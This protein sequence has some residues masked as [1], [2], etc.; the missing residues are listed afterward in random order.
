MP[1]TS[2][3]TGFLQHHAREHRVSS[4]EESDEAFS[5]DTH[6]VVLK[7]FYMKNISPFRIIV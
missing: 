2:G 5:L 6:A 7:N 4:S 1:A 3:P